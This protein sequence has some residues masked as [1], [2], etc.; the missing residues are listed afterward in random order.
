MIRRALL[1]AGVVAAMLSPA[2]LAAPA[3]AAEGP[4]A[5]LVVDTEQSGGQYRYCVALPDDRVTGIEL[6]ELAHAQHGLSYRLGY[7][8]EAVCMLAGVGTEGDDCFAEYP[9]FWGYWRGDGSGGWTWSGSG[10]RSTIVEDGDVE[11]WS[12]GSGEDGSSHPQ[13]PPTTFASVCGAREP[14]EEPGRDDEREQPKRDRERSGAA[15]PPPPT[16]EPTPSAPVES[17]ERKDRK[18]DR[19]KKRPRSKPR[20]R[21]SV[22]TPSPLSSP[23]AAPEVPDPGDGPPAAGV[24]ALGGALVLA[25]AG[26][27]IRKR[28]D[29]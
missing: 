29:L 14:V 16:P 22:A 27:F 23:I 15:A 25:A 17:R 8:G 26:I 7:G 18:E 11:G 21:P 4:H 2:T 1:C 24:A 3:C 13:P 6:I 19:N 9:D 10:G 12:W 28:R 20:A 5:V